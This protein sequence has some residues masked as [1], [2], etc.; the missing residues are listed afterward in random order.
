MFIFYLIH[1][2]IQTSVYQ[3]QHLNLIAQQMQI[4]KINLTL[5]RATCKFWDIHMNFIFFHHLRPPRI[6][7]YRSTITFTSSTSILFCGGSI[8]CARKGR[9]ARDIQRAAR[10]RETW[11]YKIDLH[12]IST[13]ADSRLGMPQY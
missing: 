5:V 4:T 12:E 11:K 7:Q 2:Y 3:R 8:W 9:I 1:T 6:T 10:I 13:L